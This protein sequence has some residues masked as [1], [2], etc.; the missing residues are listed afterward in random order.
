[1][2]VEL[3][4]SRSGPNILR[5][6]QSESRSA[7]RV[8]SPAVSLGRRS[9]F[10]DHTAHVVATR[11]ADRMRG[12]RL[13]ALG[14]EHR[15]SSRFGIMRAT[16]AGSRIGVFSFGDS[17]GILTEQKRRTSRATESLNLGVAGRRVNRT[18]APLTLRCHKQHNHRDTGEAEPFCGGKVFCQAQVVLFVLLRVF[19]VPCPCFVFSCLDVQSHLQR[20]FVVDFFQPS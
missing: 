16:F 7:E 9:R 10:D 4:P 1:M 6:Y 3:K 13:A 14:A 17:H 8:S 18:G 11:G 20:A 15:L 19:Y 12:N 5:M 2:K